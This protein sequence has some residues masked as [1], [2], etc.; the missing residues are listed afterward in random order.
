[1]KCIDNPTVYGK[2]SLINNR[3]KSSY[4]IDNILDSPTSIKSE[5]LKLNKEIKK[6]KPFKAGILGIKKFKL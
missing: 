4:H 3:I 1:M 5:K 2:V 6:A